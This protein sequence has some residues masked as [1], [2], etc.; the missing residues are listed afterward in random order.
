MHAHAHTLARSHAHLLYLTHTHSYPHV[1]THTRT[2]TA[3]HT[4]VPTHTQTR[5][6]THTCTHTATHTGLIDS[7]SVMSLLIIHQSPLLRPV[8]QDLIYFSFSVRHWKKNL[9]CVWTHHP[10][11]K[12]KVIWV[13]G[14]F[15]WK[16]CDQE[17]TATGSIW[18]Q[19]SCLQ[20]VIWM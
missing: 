1:P 8:R 13:R 17:N 15:C 4:L 16:W 9:T 10:H 3:T 18:G 5:T 19:R 6:H 7:T 12:E 20:E 14:H 2:H 11:Q